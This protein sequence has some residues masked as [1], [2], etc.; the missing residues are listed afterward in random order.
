MIGMRHV[1]NTIMT[2]QIDSNLGCPGWAARDGLP[3]IG[4]PGWAVRVGHW[5]EVF[6]S[7][8]SQTHS[9]C[10]RGRLSLTT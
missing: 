4:C 2:M 3:G 6:G 5:T 9:S 7:N 8:P 10:G 1:W